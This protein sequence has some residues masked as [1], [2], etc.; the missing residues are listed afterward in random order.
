MPVPFSPRSRIGASEVA[1][2]VAEL[3][4]ALHG[5]RFGRELAARRRRCELVLELGDAALAGLLARHAIDE[6][7]DLRRVERLGQVV[8]GAAFDRLDRGVERRVRGDHDD[9]ELR[10]DREQARQQLHAVFVTEP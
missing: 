8:D 4:G 6:V 5:L 3:D 1:A 9:G 2:R 7:A 10:A